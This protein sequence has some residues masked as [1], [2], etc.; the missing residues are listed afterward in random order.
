MAD[1]SEHDQAWDFAERVLKTAYPKAV[2][3]G[4]V[5]EGNQVLRVNTPAVRQFVFQADFGDGY[6]SDVTAQRG[7]AGNWQVFI[8]NP[9]DNKPARA[10][11]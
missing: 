10:L 6:V 8:P 4:L 11:P 2:L 5:R 7:P 9:P 1:K 3:K